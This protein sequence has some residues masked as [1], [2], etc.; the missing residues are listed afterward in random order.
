MG[1]KIEAPFH[2]PLKDGSF[3]RFDVLV[4]DFGSKLGMLITTDNNRLKAAQDELNDFEYGYSVM[5]NYSDNDIYDINEFK[6][7]LKDWGWFGDPDLYPAWLNEVSD[8]FIE[9][10]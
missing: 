7:V 2:L 4:K 1:I 5:S 3:L 9:Y 6:Y 10:N 8:E